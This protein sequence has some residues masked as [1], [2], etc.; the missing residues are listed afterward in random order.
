MADE[1]LR[2]KVALKLKLLANHEKLV[3]LLRKEGDKLDEFKGQQKDKD[4]IKQIKQKLN[5]KRK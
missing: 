5:A 1:N 4:E 2:K 3:K